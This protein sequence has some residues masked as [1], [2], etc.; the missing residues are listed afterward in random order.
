[1]A[2]VDKAFVEENNEKRKSLYKSISR[3]LDFGHLEYGECRQLPLCVC[4]RVRQI[5]PSKDGKYMGYKETYA[6][7]EE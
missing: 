1:M 2:Y 6:I 4:N 7:L 3:S 5:F